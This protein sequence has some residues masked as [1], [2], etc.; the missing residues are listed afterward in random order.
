MKILIIEEA[1]IGFS[2]RSDAS[3][4]RKNAQG[5]DTSSLRVDARL[6]NRGT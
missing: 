5:D 6:S 1:I 2:C 4:A 3:K